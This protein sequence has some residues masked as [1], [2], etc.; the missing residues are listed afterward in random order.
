MGLPSQRRRKIIEMENQSTKNQGIHLQALIS[1]MYLLS[2]LSQDC[3]DK[4][5][6]SAYPQ[7][8]QNFLCLSTSSSYSVNA[9]S[10]LM[11][12]LPKQSASPQNSLDKY[13]TCMC[14]HHQPLNSPPNHSTT[15]SSSSMKHNANPKLSQLLTT[16][17]N[18]HVDH[19]IYSMCCLSVQLC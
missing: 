12:L 6:P 13:P 16:F 17:H 18:T 3:L 5:V 4:I 15:V 9:S 19:M 10:T 11:C 8:W 1:F 2:H 14:I 7:H